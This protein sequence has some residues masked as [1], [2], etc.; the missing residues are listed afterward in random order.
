MDVDTSSSG[1]EPSAATGTPTVQE[2]FTERAV[3]KVNGDTFEETMAST[4]STYPD[5]QPPQTI[6]PADLF[7][8][9][10][11]LIRMLLQPISR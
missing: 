3:T 10:L 8:I 6:N 11:P 2:K 7:S 1:A 9:P 5:G 4:T